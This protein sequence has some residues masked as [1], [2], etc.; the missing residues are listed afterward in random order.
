MSS[1]SPRIVLW[2]SVECRVDLETMH[3]SGVAPAFPSVSIRAKA[4]PRRPW[5]FGRIAVFV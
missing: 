2:L 3:G 4:D 5:V 1:M